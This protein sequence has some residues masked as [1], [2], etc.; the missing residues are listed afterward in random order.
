MNIYGCPELLLQSMDVEACPKLE[1]LSTGCSC[2]TGFATV[3]LTQNLQYLR[4]HGSAG[5]SFGDAPLEKSLDIESVQESGLNEASHFVFELDLNQ[6]RSETHLSKKRKVVFQ[7]G[8]NLRMLL[9]CSLSLKNSKILSTL[10]G[11]QG[12]SL[13]EVQLLDGETLCLESCININKLFIREGN[14]QTISGIG[15]ATLEILELVSMKNLR[16]L[17]NIQELTTLERLTIV[18]CE[19][20]GTYPIGELSL[21]GKTPFVITHP[22]GV[23]LDFLV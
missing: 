22:D 4:I 15:L 6:Y 3:A 7:Y 20:Y 21:G 11:L 19:R 13:D 2:W 17:P 14:I 10:S 5:H 23:T 8:G 16:Y 18:G 9:L 12:L 1:R